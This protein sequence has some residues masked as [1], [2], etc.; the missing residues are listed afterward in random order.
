MTASLRAIALALLAAL[1]SCTPPP[2]PAHAQYVIGYG[3]LMHDASRERT[4]PHADAAR[5]VMVSGYQRGWYTRSRGPGPGTT[6]LGVVP[7]VASDLNAVMYKV[8]AMELA[9]TDRREGAYS[10]TLVAPS[11]VKLLA[12][13]EEPGANDQIWIYEVPAGE[14]TLVDEEHPLAQSYVDVFVSGCL[15]QEERYHLPDFALRCVRTTYGWSGQWVNDRV[16]P[17]RAFVFE[18]RSSQIDKLLSAELP[19]YW[20][21]MRIEGGQ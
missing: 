4:A 15:E 2:E 19:D 10:R 5:P 14:A 21:H 20:P 13:G 17:R 8:D 12:A 7:D 6:Y 9:A 1:G 11:A 3:S 18:P 16:Y